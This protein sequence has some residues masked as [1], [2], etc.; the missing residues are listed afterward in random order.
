MINNIHD[1]AFICPKCQN[2]TLI[3]LELDKVLGIGYGD[4]C[5]CEECAAELKAI[6]NYDYTVNFEDIKEQT[7]LQ[8]EDIRDIYGDR[9]IKIDEVLLG[10]ELHLNIKCKNYKKTIKGENNLCGTQMI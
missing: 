3:P 5:I 7:Y 2:K 10:K 6:P 4:I 1:K 8:I 9:N